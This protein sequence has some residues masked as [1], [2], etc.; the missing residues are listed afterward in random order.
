MLVHRLGTYVHLYPRVNWSLFGSKDGRRDDL[1]AHLPIWTLMEIC[2]AR[3]S[4]PLVR[5]STVRWASTDTRLEIRGKREGKVNLIDHIAATKCER[6][7]RADIHSGT[8]QRHLD[9]SWLQFT[10]HTRCLWCT[11][12]TKSWGLGPTLVNIRPVEPSM[13]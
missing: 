12:C 13:T 9:F 3:Q 4:F 5:V 1:S 10:L 8:Q 7:M 6:D 11:P 2:G